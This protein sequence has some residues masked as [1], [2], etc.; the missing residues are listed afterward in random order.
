MSDAIHR[1]GLM[2]VLSSPSGAGKTTLAR[3]LLA[4]D[5]QISMS[6]SVTTRPARP[7]EIDGQDYYFLSVEEFKSKIQKEAFVEW[8]EVYEDHFYGTL[9]V[10]VERI[11]KSGKAVIFDVDVVGGGGLVKVDMLGVSL[12]VEKGIKRVRGGYERCGYV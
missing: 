1:R 8:E 12:G 11:W 2:L 3:S 4:A 10:E 7:G 5:S 9:K 6:V